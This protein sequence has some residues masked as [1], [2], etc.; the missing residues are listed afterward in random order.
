MAVGARS[1]EIRSVTERLVK[2][3]YGKVWQLRSGEQWK[4]KS[5]SVPVR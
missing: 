5:G 1:G 2:L 4:G 3:R